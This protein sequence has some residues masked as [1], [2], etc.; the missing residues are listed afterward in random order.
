MGLLTNPSSSSGGHPLVQILRQHAPWLSWLLYV[1]GVVSFLALAHPYY[2]HNT[3]FSENALLPGLVDPGFNDEKTIS[4]TLEAIKEEAQNYPNSVPFPWIEAQ[5]RQLGLE[6]YTHNFSLNYPLGQ[7]RKFVGQN[8]YAILRAPR[9]SSNEALVFSVPYR[10]PY[11]LDQGTEASLAVLMASAKFFNRQHYWAKD[12]IFLVT[13][14]EQLGMQA[15]LEAYHQRSCGSGALEHGD[16]PARAGSIQAAINL[17][18]SSLQFTHFNFRLEG[19]NG[20]LPNLDLFN[21]VNQLC[22]REGVGRMFQGVEEY[23]KGDH[24]RR[25][26]VRDPFSVSWKEYERG[27]STLFSM[28]SKQATGVP[29]GNHGLFHRFG[30]EA[31]TI[32]GVYHRKR[33]NHRE[34]PLASVGRIMESVFRSLNNLLERFHQS[35]FFYLLPSS[36]QY[37]SIGMYMPGFGLLAGSLVVLALG[38]WCECVAKSQKE[39]NSSNPEKCLKDI[40]GESEKSVKQTTVPPVVCPPSLGSTLPV[41]ILAH[42]LGF[43]V[44]HLPRP[45]SIAG[46]NFNLETEDSIALGLIG[47]SIYALALPKFLKNAVCVT[48]QNWAVLKCVIL[49]EIALLGFSVALSNFSLG[50][51]VTTLYAPVALMSGPSK[52]GVKRFFK[53]LTTIF[54]HPLVLILMVCSLDTIRTFSDYHVG[55]MTTMCLDASKRALCYSITDGFIYG[56]TNFQIGSLLVFPC[57]HILWSLN[58]THS[59][60]EEPKKVEEP[61]KEVSSKADIKALKESKKDQ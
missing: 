7:G 48:V 5:F 61:A 1:L 42:V 9:A 46:A 28:A 32:E 25:R 40:K 21:L 18:M 11:S 38:M 17:E 43:I 47:F 57:W 12:I 51:F 23:V 3:Y 60:S 55:K 50:F 53:M 24:H 29:S 35:F 2:A 19:L 14:H 41:L 15:W 31:L 22:M 26:K 56:S 16:L 33:K 4:R 58:F 49:I 59:V 52:S 39:R 10:P 8:V 44:T 34:V 13:Q 27:L 54:I 30:I 36:S 6:V 45:I 20:Q 37:V